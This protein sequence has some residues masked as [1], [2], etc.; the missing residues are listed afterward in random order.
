MTWPATADRDGSA[1]LELP[2]SAPGLTI[3]GAVVGDEAL[4]VLDRDADAKTG[5][6]GRVA[7]RSRARLG[8][9]RV[10]HL[11][12]RPAVASEATTESESPRVRTAAF[13]LDGHL[14]WLCKQGAAE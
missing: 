3:T 10:S 9:G 5:G 4:K 12:Y 2:A 11:T 14:I 7:A 8:Q 13:T 1:V 6:R